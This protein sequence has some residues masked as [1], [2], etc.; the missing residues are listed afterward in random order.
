MAV[1]SDGEGEEKGQERSSAR[2]GSPGYREPRVRHPPA[3]SDALAAESL[4]AAIRKL[5][6]RVTRGDSF[7][8][9]RGSGELPPLHSLPGILESCKFD[10]DVAQGPVIVAVFSKGWKR[11]VEGNQ[12]GSFAGKQAVTQ[13]VQAAANPAE[14]F[15]RACAAAKERE[16]PM[17]ATG[18]VDLD[19]Q[20]AAHFMASNVGKLCH[21]RDLSYKPVCALA[22]RLQPVTEALRKQQEGTACK[23]AGGILSAFLPWP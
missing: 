1:R 4:A 21:A 19:V 16:F 10:A 20:F 17:D 12:K 14:H 22:A 23:L 2:H 7:P 9:C 11:A 3:C 13:V 6:S 8:I 15:Q 18:V 5:A